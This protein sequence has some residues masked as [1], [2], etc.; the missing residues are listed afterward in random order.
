M[1][2]LSMMIWMTW[3]SKLV[4]WSICPCLVFLLILLS[5]LAYTENL[6][7]KVVLGIRRDKPALPENNEKGK[8]G[9]LDCKVGIGVPSWIIPLSIYFRKTTEVELSTC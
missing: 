5:S 6:R 7:V 8:V 3:I 1:M 4:E 9:A 2:K